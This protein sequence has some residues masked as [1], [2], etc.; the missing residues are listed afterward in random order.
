MILLG[1][2]NFIYSLVYFNGNG[3][4]FNNWLKQKKEKNF[5]VYSNS[6]H[7]NTSHWMSY[8]FIPSLLFSSFSHFWSLSKK[9]VVCYPS[10]NVSFTYVMIW[11]E[12]TCLYIPFC[13]LRWHTLSV[14]TYPF[15]YV[16]T[17]LRDFTS[18]LLLLCGLLLYIISVNFLENH[19]FFGGCFFIHRRFNCL[20]GN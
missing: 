16:C 9:C 6:Q 18:Y 10:Q 2:F 5:F 14:C 1:C 12:L 7:V 4:F 19:C 17:S 15:V 11:Y 8:R 20:L 3:P 13:L